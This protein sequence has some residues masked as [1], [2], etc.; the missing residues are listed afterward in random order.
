MR[1]H[2]NQTKVNAVVSYPIEV[3]LDALEH[4]IKSKFT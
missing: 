4:D 2:K 1:K 3:A